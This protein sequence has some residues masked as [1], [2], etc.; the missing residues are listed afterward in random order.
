MRKHPM[1]HILVDWARPWV[2][3][4]RIHSEEESTVQ[5]K[6][7]TLNLS[8]LICVL[9][10]AVALPQV[11]AQQGTPSAIRPADNSG[12]EA[13]FKMAASRVVF[14]IARKVN[15]IHARAS[16]IILTADGYIATSFHAV[17]GADSVEIRYFPDPQDSETYQSFNGARLL[18]ANPDRD[19]AILKVNGKAL[20]FLD[21][22]A[23]TNSAPRIGEAVFAIGNPKGLNNTISEGIVS[24]LRSTNG[25]NVIQHTAAISPGSSGGALLDSTGDLLGMSALAP[26]EP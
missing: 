19:V 2:H 23:A 3:D 12:A 11:H 24:A 8:L 18:Y 16:G 14:L 9:I 6:G 17:Q 4:S 7:H 5:A 20:P 25:E 15:D 21:C 13:V 26:R 10:A 22:Q 1:S